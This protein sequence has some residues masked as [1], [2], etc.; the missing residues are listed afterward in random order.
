M[1]LLTI[2]IED[3]VADGRVA[4]EYATNGW[5]LEYNMLQ[6]ESGTAL[7]PTYE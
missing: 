7:R 4:V 3:L 5:K 6:G 2:L 1:L